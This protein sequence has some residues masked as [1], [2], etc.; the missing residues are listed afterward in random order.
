MF[1]L[2]GRV[3]PT[4]DDGSASNSTSEQPAVPDMVLSLIHF[5]GEQNQSITDLSLPWAALVLLPHLR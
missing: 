1:F 2:S 3:F 5:P 4:K